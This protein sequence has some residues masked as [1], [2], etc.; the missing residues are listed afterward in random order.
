[1]LGCELQLRGPVQRT[2]PLPT[3]QI[4]HPPIPTCTH[5]HTQVVEALLTRLREAAAK[6]PAGFALQPVPFEKDDDSNYHMQARIHKKESD[7]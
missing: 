7:Y 6:Y 3:A 4:P 1:M 5:T 2:P